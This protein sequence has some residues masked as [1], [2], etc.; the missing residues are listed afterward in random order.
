MI[1][2]GVLVDFWRATKFTPGH[3]GHILVKPTIVQVLYQGREPLVELR[4]MG[5]LHAIE[6]VAVEVPTAEVEGDDAGTS[7]DEPAR[8]EKVLK[9]PG[10]TVTKTVGISLAIAFPN[11]LRLLRNV[12]GL[13]EPKI[14]QMPA[15]ATLVDTSR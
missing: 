7:L 8:H 3:H 14:K 10:S 15:S 1:T 12:E 6:R 13:C 11:M 5:V 4:Q 9:I 2:T